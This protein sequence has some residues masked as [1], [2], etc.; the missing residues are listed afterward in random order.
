MSNH[1]KQRPE[2]GGRF[3]LW[4]IRGI[5]RH[6]GRSV[7]RALLYPITLYFLLVRGPERTASRAYL[8]RVLGR[9][10]TVRDVARHIHTFASTILDRVYMLC[11]QMQRFQVDITGWIN[12]TRRWT[13]AV[14]C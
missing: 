13:A 11:G 10:A 5:A 14:A 4:L 7:G 1:W 3:A 6:A 12:C 9:P 8:A 2:G